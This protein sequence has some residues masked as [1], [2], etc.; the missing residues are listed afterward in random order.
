MKGKLFW[1]EKKRYHFTNLKCTCN[2]FLCLTICASVIQVGWACRNIFLGHNGSCHI[3]TVLYVLLKSMS[4]HLVCT[5][6]KKS[7]HYLTKSRTAFTILLALIPYFSKSTVAGPDL[8]TSFT[9][10]FFTVIFLSSATALSTASPRPPEL[11]KWNY[12][13]NMVEWTPTI[14][15]TLQG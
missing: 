14:T 3:V 8:G 11:N 10:S 4:T 5:V 9:A 12:I 13:K 7:T 15:R 6:P 1:K 2:A